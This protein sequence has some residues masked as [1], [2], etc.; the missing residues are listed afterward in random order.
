LRPLHLCARTGNSETLRVLLRGKADVDAA[1]EDG[2]RALH[3][4]AC[5]KDSDFVSLLLDA[6][7]DPTAKNCMGETAMDNAWNEDV[8]GIFD[9]KW[10]N[11][12]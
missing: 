6:R 5:R 3:F 8:R 4:A 12:A 11:D 10:S 7:A 1:N 2:D 9:L